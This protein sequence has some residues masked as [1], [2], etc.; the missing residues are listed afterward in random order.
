MA[1]K[2]KSTKTPV[3]NGKP[4]PKRDEKNEGIKARFNFVQPIGQSYIRL[5]VEVWV[6]PAERWVNSPESKR[7]GWGSQLLPGDRI[8]AVRVL[9]DSEEAKRS[10]PQWEAHDEPEPD[11]VE[12]FQDL[13]NRLLTFFEGDDAVTGLSL[14]CG[15]NGTG[16]FEVIL[17]DGFKGPGRRLPKPLK[18]HFGCSAWD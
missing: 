16:T 3:A 15:G 6:L 18:V 8:I 13:R 12:L 14:D 9:E 4:A 11:E 10:D 1:T 2:S 5:I 17:D 7:N